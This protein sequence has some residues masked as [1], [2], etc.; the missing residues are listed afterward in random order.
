MKSGVSVR[1][2]DL[3]GDFHVRP[4]AEGFL[5][6]RDEALEVLS[7]KRVGRAAAKMKVRHAGMRAERLGPDVDL[8]MQR[9]QIGADPAVAVRHAGGTAAIEA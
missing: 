4:C 1:G 3:N 7:R 9:F 6:V 2:V 8:L 5:G